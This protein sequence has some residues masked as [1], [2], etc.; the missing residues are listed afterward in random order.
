M[1]FVKRFSPNTPYEEIRREARL[2]RVA[3]GMGLA[4]RI[5]RC[6]KTAIVME[7]LNAPSLAEVYGDDP[8]DVPLWIRDDILD[9]LYTLY[10]V[11]EIEYIDVT[12]YNFIERDGVVWI[13]DFGHAQRR[14]GDIDPYLD[15]IFANW[16]ITKWNSEFA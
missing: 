9:I 12:P 1:S 6:T 3:A 5:T 7:N 11:A 10:T 16:S 14:S 13:I 2:Q 8:E 4:P 15:E